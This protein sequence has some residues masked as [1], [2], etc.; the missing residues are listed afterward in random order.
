MQS[1]A[2]RMP[3]SSKVMSTKKIRRCFFNAWGL[4]CYFRFS[5]CAYAGD[6][7]NAHVSRLK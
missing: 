6:R 7:E 3:E 2:V 1:S 5:A 4:I